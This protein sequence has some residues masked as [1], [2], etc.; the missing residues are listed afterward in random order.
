[1]PSSNGIGARKEVHD[2]VWH[3]RDRRVQLG[4]ISVLMMLYSKR[5][6]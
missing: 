6:D 4:I 1:M 3:A 2:A 5:P